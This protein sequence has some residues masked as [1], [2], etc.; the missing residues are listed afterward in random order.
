M[1][2]II[3]NPQLIDAPPTTPLHYGLFTAVSSVQTMDRRLIA[4][5]GQFF[6]DHC[7][8]GQLYNQTCLESPEKTFVEGSDI[9]DFDP[10]W[11]VA[12]K[13]CGAVGR[14]AGEMLAAVRT[15]LLTSQQTLVEGGFWGGTVVPVDPNL[16]GNAGTTVVTPAAPGFGAAI[17]ALEEAFYSVY[18][19]TGTIH[20]N[21]AAY[22]AAAYS[23]LIV[24]QGGAGVLRTP[25]GSAWSFGA[26]YGI[27]GPAGV[28]PAAGFVW[29][30]MTGA[31]HMWRSGVLPQPDPRQTLDRSL[32]QW[33]VIAEEIFGLT[34]DCPEV[35]AVQVP[36]AAPAVATAP[37]VP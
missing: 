28:A 12:R 36:V 9:M 17:A 7:G 3:T 31:V 22:G 29:A 8:D 35:F 16:I 19:Y 30:F 32:N 2:K 27:T 37:A 21:M 34:W 25:M 23:Q 33:D 18:G 24:R 10:F 15:Q 14:T 1:G 4:S 5:G 26:G 13:R 11:T 6:A 20:V